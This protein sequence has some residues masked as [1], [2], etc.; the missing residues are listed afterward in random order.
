MEKK[1]VVIIQDNEKRNMELEKIIG[2][3]P[4]LEVVGVATDGISGYRLLEEKKPD[5]DVSELLRA[6][7]YHCKGVIQG[8]GVFHR[9]A[10]FLRRVDRTAPRS[11]R[12]QGRAKGARVRRGRKAEFSGRKN[13]QYFYQR[14]YT[15]AH[16]RVCLSAGRRQ[17]GGG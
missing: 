15:A 4:D 1:S 6:G 7:R 11:R 16:Q 8:S 13:Q 9:Q 2:A 10:V 14:R 12:K 3:T 5:F 17:D